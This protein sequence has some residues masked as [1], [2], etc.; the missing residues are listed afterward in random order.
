MSDAYPSYLEEFSIEIADYNPIGPACHIP[1]P[2]TMPKRNN[3]VINMQNNDDWCFGWCVLG[4]LHPVKV[5]PERNPHRI[6][7]KYI[8]ELNMEDIP[9]PVPVS[10]PVYQKFE[11]NNPEISL[12]VYEW[13]NQNKCL[14]FRYL[15]E[16]R[17]AE[18]KQVNLLVISEADDLE[19]ITVLL[20][21]YIN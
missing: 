12:C 9:I 5:H 17:S 14:E 15:S 19:N 8:E 20:R 21:I 18:F 6:Y 11:E 10:T 13:S 4:S 16:R 2:E 7:A 3:G 1:L